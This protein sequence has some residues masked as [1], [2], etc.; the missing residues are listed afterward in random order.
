MI[1]EVAS[2]LGDFGFSVSAYANLLLFIRTELRLECRD[3]YNLVSI[4]RQHFSVQTET[5]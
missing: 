4:E 5:Q 3:V 2:L 1:I